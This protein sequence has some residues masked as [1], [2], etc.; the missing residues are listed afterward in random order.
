MQYGPPVNPQAVEPGYGYTL[1]VPLTE[2][3]IY[4][5]HS[6][7][8]GSTSYITDAD[9]N[10]TQFVCYMPFGEAFV[11]E[12]TTRTE[13]PFKF[14]GK[15]QDAETGL[16]YYGARYYDAK[17]AVW[18]GVDKMIEKHPN[19][20]PFA[21]CYNNPVKFIDPFGLDTFKIN[22]DNRS[23]D[24]ITVDGS[25]SHTY[26]IL[27]DGSVVST[28]SLAV[29]EFGLVQF[30]AS[31]PGFGRYGTE[32]AARIKNGETTGCEEGT[33]TTNQI[34][35][36]PGDHY[37]RPDVAAALFGLSSEIASLNGA[38]VDFGDM[39]NAW[40]MAPGD[41]HKTHGGGSK[42]NYVSIFSGTSIDYRY[43][44]SS[45]QSYQGNA[46]DGQFHKFTNIAFLYLAGE[47]GFNKNYISNKKE[48]WNMGPI[49]VNGKKIGGHNDHGHLTYTK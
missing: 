19:Y 20:T 42:S 1:P 13:M 39:S 25:E 48:I 22:I 40:G 43:L 2:D 6:D 12:H 24:R 32:D 26:V 33:T 18:Y 14:N 30:P 5:Y 28:Q 31:G 21:Y 10:A 44:N 4:F 36:G 3:D 35:V 17:I 47:W 9:A 38:R 23:V 49:E 29:N 41:D 15:E 45:F 37:L 7:H 8:L 46:T 27:K 16:Y 34:N 11:D